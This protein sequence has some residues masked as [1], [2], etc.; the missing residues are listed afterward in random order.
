MS[1]RTI[2]TKSLMSIEH[3]GFTIH[4]VKPSKRITWRVYQ[5]VEY[6]QTCNTKKDAI[7]LIDFCLDNKIW[8][9][10]QKRRRIETW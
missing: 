1:S 10:N 2:N 8:T 4:K 7:R 3:R 9:P 6:M 5:F